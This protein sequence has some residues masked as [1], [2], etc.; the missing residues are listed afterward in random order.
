MALYG[1]FD[2]TDQQSIATVRPKIERVLCELSSIIFQNCSNFLMELLYNLFLYSGYAR[3]LYRAMYEDTFSISIFCNDDHLVSNGLPALTNTGALA[4]DEYG[5]Q[6]CMFPRYNP[7]PRIL[8]RAKPFLHSVQIF[9]RVPWY[10]AFKQQRLGNVMQ[11][12][13]GKL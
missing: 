12:Q 2:E 5:R 7:L 11:I 1:I 4:K 9:I 8:Q 3:E 13:I 10:L 6:K